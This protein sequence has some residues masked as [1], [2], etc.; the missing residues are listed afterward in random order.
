MIYP[1]HEKSEVLKT[2][3][4][5]GYLLAETENNDIVELLIL[6]DGVVPAHALPIDVVFYVISG[7]GKITITN[8]VTNA[9]KGDVITVKKNLDRTWQNPFDE[10]L[11]LLVI[12]Q[13]A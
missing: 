6:R 12:K 11:K 9:L 3:K 8:E 2:E 10:P 4:A 13:K 5:C 1:Y 7:R